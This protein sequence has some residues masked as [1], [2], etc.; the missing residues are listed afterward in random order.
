[1]ISRVAESC[2]W[3]YRYVE[4]VESTAR[5]L[6]VNHAFVL[7]LDLPEGERWWPVVVVSGEQHRI[8]DHLTKAQLSDGDCIQDYFTWNS[9]SPVSII[10]SLHWA[11]E[12]GRTIR[13]VISLEMWQSLNGFWHWMKSGPAKRLYKSDRDAFYRRVR[14]WAATFYGMATGTM[15]HEQPFDFMNLGMLLERASWTARAVD[16]KHHT[17]GEREA[18]AQETPVEAA[19]A[20]ALLR[21]CSAQEPFFKQVRGTPTGKRVVAFLLTARTFPRSVL[22]CLMTAEDFLEQIAS[23]SAGHGADSLA[24]LRALAQ[25]V[26][27][28]QPELM[29]QSETHA[30]LTHVINNTADICGKIQGDY[31]G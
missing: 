30:L 29:S 19:Q 8:G 21:Y 17:V 13:E 3:L 20:L 24:A 4:R 14:E 12:N 23:Q 10:S 11:R 25:E 31:F 7:D 6:E 27:E 1:M 15:L 2:F 5:L 9:E 22:H 18:G 16:V 26:A 28:L